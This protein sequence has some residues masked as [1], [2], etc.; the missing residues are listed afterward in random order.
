MLKK[1]FVR[2]DIRT[3]LFSV[4][5]SENQFAKKVSCH[6][7]NSIKLT[8]ISTV[9]TS[10]WILHEPVGFAVAAQRLFTIFT[11]NWIFQNIITNTTDQFRQKSFYVTQVKYPFFFVDKL[12]ILF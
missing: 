11:F 9:W 12:L 5:A 3:P 4:A 10:V 1:F 6:S 2:K 8:F 7:V